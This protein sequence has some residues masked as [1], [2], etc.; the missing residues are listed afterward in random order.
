VLTLF[1]IPGMYTFLA[2]KKRGSGE[3]EAT[4]VVPEKEAEKT[5]EV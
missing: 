3:A 2:A 4:N 1:V 5:V